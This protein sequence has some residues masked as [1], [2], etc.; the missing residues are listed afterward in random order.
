[1]FNEKMTGVD[2]A[3]CETPIGEL[4]WE[5]NDTTHVISFR[6]RLS[7]S[8]IYRLILGRN[9]GYEN[10]GGIPLEE[11]TLTFTTE[12]NPEPV[13]PTFIDTTPIGM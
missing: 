7:P 2:V 9:G 5:D 11:Y 1:M 12:G 4:W 8:K 13:T 10:M 6:E 3:Y